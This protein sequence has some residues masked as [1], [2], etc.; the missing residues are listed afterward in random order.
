[1]EQ[2]EKEFDDYSLFVANNRNNDNVADIVALNTSVEDNSLSRINF[3]RS[4]RLMSNHRLVKSTGATL[5]DCR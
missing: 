4:F 3:Q 2:S 5:T 1:M